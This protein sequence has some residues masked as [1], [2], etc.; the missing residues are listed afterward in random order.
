MWRRIR[1]FFNIYREGDVRIVLRYSET[2]D[3]KYSLEYLTIDGWVVSGYFCC[4]AEAKKNIVR[5]N[6]FRKIV[7]EE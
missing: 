7:Y 6:D 4:I 2:Q 1:K 5:D 3:M